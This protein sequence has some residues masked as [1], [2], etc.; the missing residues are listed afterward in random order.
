MNQYLITENTSL[1]YFRGPIAYNRD[2]FSPYDAITNN[3]KRPLFPPGYE[4]PYINKH[5]G[6]PSNRDKASVLGAVGMYGI[7][8]FIHF[9]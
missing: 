7:S 3:Q 8:L 9:Q 1:L 2:R 6:I 4:N 5:F